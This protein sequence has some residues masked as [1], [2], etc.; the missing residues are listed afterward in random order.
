MD[1]VDGEL[2]PDT[3]REIETHLAGCET[4]WSYVES[5]KS[6]LVAL[7]NDSVPEPPEAYFAY[8]SGRARQRAHAGRKRRVLTFAPGLAAAA[9]VV[10]LMWWI[11]GVQFPPVDSVDIIMTDMTTAGLVEAVS[12]DPYAES[13][14]VGSSEAGLDEIRAYLEETESI[15]DLLETMSDAEKA[16]FIA[17]LEGSMAEDGKT[18]GLATGSVRKEC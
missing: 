7:D 17:Y 5:L 6:T 16:R 8:L 3:A 15:H 9:A 14:I 18:S 10:A 1:L 4:C 13:L 2:A 12:T 11:T